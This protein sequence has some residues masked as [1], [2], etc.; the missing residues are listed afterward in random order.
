MDYPDSNP[1]MPELDGG[2]EQLKLEC[3]QYELKQEK[4]GGNIIECIPD[5]ISQE[6]VRDR[7]RD[8]K[9]NQVV[10]DVDLSPDKVLLTLQGEVAMTMAEVCLKLDDSV[11]RYK[12]YADYLKIM[13]ADLTTAD[14]C[15]EVNEALLQT[16]DPELSRKTVDDWKRNI[17]DTL[18]KIDAYNKVLDEFY[19]TTMVYKIGGGDKNSILDPCEQYYGILGRIRSATVTPMSSCPNPWRDPLGYIVCML[20]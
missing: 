9:N 17:K 18:E 15:R 13:L 4:L 14:V 20:D 1:S 10:G 11:E 3:E 2:A 19:E 12:R 7:I 6:K 16:D 5:V 8:I